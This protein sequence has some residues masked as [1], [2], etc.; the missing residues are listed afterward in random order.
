MDPNLTDKEKAEKMAKDEGF[1]NFLKDE[2]DDEIKLK[3]AEIEDE[4]ETF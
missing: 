3:E 1:Q 2:V 4:K